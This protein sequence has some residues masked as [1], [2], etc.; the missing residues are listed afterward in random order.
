MKR[1]RGPVLL[2]SL[3]SLGVAGSFVAGV[4]GAGSS[5][6]MSAG[7][8]FVL[9]GGKGDVHLVAG[10]ALRGHVE[11]G[12]VIGSASRIT[13]RGFQFQRVA[14]SGRGRVWRGSNLRFSAQGPYD[15]RVIAV[16]MT[17]TATGRGRVT[18]S[19]QGFS[20]PGRFSIDGGPYRSLPRSPRTFSFGH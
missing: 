11:T 17:I 16:G 15:L 10:G 3:M 20:A 5:R 1:R 2:V 18:L 13:V 7:G 8:S 4:Y 19:S 14:R 12:R 9:R 6:A